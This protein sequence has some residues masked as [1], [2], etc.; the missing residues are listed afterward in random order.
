MTTMRLAHARTS[1][2]SSDTMMT[3]SPC[4][5]SLRISA[6]MSYFEPM[7]TPIVG[8]FRMRTLR[9]FASHR[10]RTTFC[11]LP[12][13]RVQTGRDGSIVAIESSAIQRSV[14]SA[15]ALRRM[16]PNQPDRRS[17]TATTRLRSI[18]CGRKS[19]SVRRSDGT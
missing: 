19:P 13:E 4:A 18:A 1:G 2:R 6:W 15:T 12:P 11:W 9:S 8:P 14:V 7:S 3:A 5:A 16:T 17:S 10:A